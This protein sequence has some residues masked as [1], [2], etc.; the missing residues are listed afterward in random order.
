MLRVVQ[1]GARKVCGTLQQMREGARRFIVAGGETSGAVTKA[2]GVNALDIG[3]EIAPGVPWTFCK[4]A[5]YDIALAL[6]SGNF[7][8]EKF[9]SHAQS[10]LEAK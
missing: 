1:I 2:L 3:R 6:K 10:M 4:S 7:G 9:F 5:G 8:T